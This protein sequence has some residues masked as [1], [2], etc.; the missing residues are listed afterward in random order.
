MASAQ[1]PTAGSF[2][3]T[4]ARDLL[5]GVNSKKRKRETDQ[6]VAFR[7]AFK[8]GS[9]TP[10]TPGT[11]T[12]DASKNHLMSFD[13]PSGGQQVFDAREDTSKSREC[14][15]IWDA[16]T[17]SFILHLLPTTLSLSLNRTLSSTSRRTAAAAAA[18]SPSNEELSNSSGELRHQV[19][20]VLGEDDHDDTPK[21]KKSRPSQ[22]PT[23]TPRPA[24]SGKSLPR[25]TPAALPSVSKKAP[26][27]KP[28]PTTGKYKS[29]E[30][31]DDSDEGAGEEEEDEFAK[32]MG[33]TL[34]A[35]ILQAKNEAYDDEEEDDEEEDEDEDDELGGARL[36]VRQD[37]VAPAVGNRAKSF[38]E[39][40]GRYLA[41]STLNIL[42]T[43][44]SGI[45]DDSSD[46]ESE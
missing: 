9:I 28:P 5:D 39:A 35:E 21:S 46:D 22:V 40:L 31:I 26:K 24:Q 20:S 45:P 14:A 19:S 30:I 42:L 32:M 1:I 7:Y 10:S 29:V 17:Q 27:K 11:L 4:V 36:I 18:D 44:D 34:A 41:N 23:P 33:E 43:A 13:L 37:N 38:S 6:L 25:K 12:T 2:P 3:M 8:P 16:G 15:L